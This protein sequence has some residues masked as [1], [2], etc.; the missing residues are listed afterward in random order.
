[1][2]RFLLTSIFLFTSLAS[3]GLEAHA[4]AHIGLV[5]TATPEPLIPLPET[6]TPEPLIPLPP[7][8]LI[9]LGPEFIP[10]ASVPQYDPAKKKRLCDAA[11]RQ[12]HQFTQELSELKRE[13][14]PLIEA[15]KKL[16]KIKS[17][18]WAKEAAERMIAII[19][20]KATRLAA[21]IEWIRGALDALRAERTLLGC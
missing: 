5:A 13:I 21:D 12:I 10:T 7:A 2:N 20:E 1:M 16:R 9:P 4:E 3:F 15:M 19:L 6:P 17:P 8:T 18:A 14:R 11:N